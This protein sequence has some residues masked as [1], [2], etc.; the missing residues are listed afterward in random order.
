MIRN[1]KKVCLDQNRKAKVIIID[2][3]TDEPEVTPNT[4][5]KIK[6]KEK[7]HHEETSNPYEK[8]RQIPEY[9][10]TKDEMKGDPTALIA[11]LQEKYI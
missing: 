10:L 3:E 9:I 6:N 1:R 4:V 2:S 8:I 11:K 5:K 7:C